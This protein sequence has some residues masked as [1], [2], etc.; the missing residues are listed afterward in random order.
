[1]DLRLFCIVH[2]ISS[3][4]YIV[5]RPTRNGIYIEAT[6]THWRDADWAISECDVLNQRVRDCLFENDNIYKD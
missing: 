5:L 2:Q 4:D 1:M 3:G 6:G